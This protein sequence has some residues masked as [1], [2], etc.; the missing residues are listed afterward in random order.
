MSDIHLYWFWS[1]NPQ[2]VRF[3]LEE[4]KLSYTLHKI[5][6]GKKENQ[7]SE[8]LSI[9]PKG[10]VPA[11]SID[12][13]LITESNA[14]LLSLAMRF[15]RLWPSSPQEQSK[16]MELLFFESSTFSS[17]AGTHYSNLVIR[18]LIGAKPNKPAVLKAKSKLVPILDR[19][20]EHFKK[21]HT[22]LTSTFSIVDC[23]YGVWL[24][25]I[26]LDAHPNVRAW[27]DRLMN[28]EGWNKA[29]LRQ[30][31]TKQLPMEER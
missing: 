4:M 6:L 28:K 17:L 18:P 8:Y 21:G 20:E 15:H 2:K 26:C 27:R 16:A 1:T 12:G 30:T 22:Y 19:F 10:Q 29:E 3:A 14:I 5:D 7:S 25:H 23:A 9:N 31:I 11:L 24:P 13:Q